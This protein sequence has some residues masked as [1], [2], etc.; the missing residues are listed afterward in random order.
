MAYECAKPELM[1]FDPKG[2]QYS[3]IKTEE[4]SFKPLA[5]IENSNIIQFGNQGNNEDYRN[6]A[7]TYISIKVKM[8]HKKDPDVTTKV[9][10][11]ETELTKAGMKVSCVNNLLHSL[12]RQVTLTLNGKQIAQNNMNYSYRWVYF[13]FFDL[14]F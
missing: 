13:Y 12:F 9:S 10:A 1:F 6:L 14:F 8:N 5:S 3:I 7:S 2:V 4:Q 11:D